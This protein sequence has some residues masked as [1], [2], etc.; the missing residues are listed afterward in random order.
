VGLVQG[1]AVFPGISRSGS[2]IAA[3]LFLGLE[4]SEAF[5]LSFLMSVPA[6]LGASLLEGIK[7]LRN[8]LLVLPEG[9]VWAVLAAFALGCLSLA[10]LRRL[11]L[12]GRWAYF[13]IYCFLLGVAVIV[14][15]ITGNF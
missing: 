11:V 4:A 5:R 8:P 7:V 2:T 6:I 9:W 3:A 1:L 12:S 14:V 13:G 10:F 15:A